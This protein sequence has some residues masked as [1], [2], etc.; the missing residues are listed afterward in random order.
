MAVLSCV[1]CGSFTEP[2]VSP[3]L[4]LGQR[5]FLASVA[6]HT[7]ARFVGG[8]RVEILLDGDGTFPR[9]L[10][11]IRAA[12]R[13]ITFLQ[14][15]YDTGPIAD[16]VANALAERCAHGVKVHVLLDSVGAGGIRSELVSRMRDSGCEVEWF[17][18]VKAL[19]FLTPW[20]LLA[21]NRRNHRRILVVDGRV[22]FTGGY[23]VST[24]WM[25][26]GRHPDGWRD[27]NV[28]IEGPVVQ[29]LQAAFV[30]N[31]SATT[32]TV[33]VGS[34]YFP[35]LDA[36]GAVKAQIVK[37]SP[38]AGASESCM[39]FLLAIDAARRSIY[40]TNPYFVGDGIW[41]TVGSTNLDRRSFELNEELNLTVFDSHLARRLE[42]IFWSDLQLA[43]EVTQAK[44][45]MR[46]PKQRVFELF[47]F[48]AKSQL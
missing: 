44:W 28:E 36:A 17:R 16:D 10:Q 29:Q 39:M 5:S 26:D 46:G 7:D 40:V 33:L 34:D 24:A 19:Q 32:G 13:S 3:P 41:A 31:W 6:A 22:G 14:Y 2:R 37:S 48:P 21:Y 43:D 23:G 18:R 12:R 8:N 11:A 20:E 30:Q 47:A 45:Q 38:G 15:F 9:I 4:D 42:D 25:G 27:T 1:A 35:S